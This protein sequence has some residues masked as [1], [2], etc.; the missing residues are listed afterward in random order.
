[1]QAKSISSRKPL[2]PCWL[3]IYLVLVELIHGSTMMDADLF[4]FPAVW[5]VLSGVADICTLSL[6]MLRSVI[7]KFAM[8]F[9]RKTNKIP[10]CKKSQRYDL[11]SNWGCIALWGFNVGFAHKI[12]HEHGDSERPRWDGQSGGVLATYQVAHHTG[13]H[14]FIFSLSIPHIK[15]EIEVKWTL[16]LMNNLALCMTMI[17]TLCSV[18]TS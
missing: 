10:L 6:I 2:G 5:T 13:M 11:W 17:L 1:M 15:S 3:N 8:A 14:F 12:S 16:T 18:A 9:P 4:P 7:S